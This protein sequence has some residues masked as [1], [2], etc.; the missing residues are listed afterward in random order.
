[1]NSVTNAKEPVN[2]QGA[3][4]KV[5][6]VNVE[7]TEDVKNVMVLAVLENLIISACFSSRPFYN[8]TKYEQSITENIT[9][10]VSVRY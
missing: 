3:M 8:K 4:V 5:S 1:M 10:T 6:A 2:V 7:V 9:T